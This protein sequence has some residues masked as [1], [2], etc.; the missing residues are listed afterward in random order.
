MY[1]WD[2]NFQ[3]KNHTI[4]IGSTRKDAALLFNVRG[5]SKNACSY[6]NKTAMPLNDSLGFFS[7]EI[8]TFL[9]FFLLRLGRMGCAGTVCTGCASNVGTVWGMQVLYCMYR[10]CWKQDAIWRVYGSVREFI[11]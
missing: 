8:E 5:E 6:I 1:R 3:I 10:V 11:D 4:S 2:T 7:Y 9:A